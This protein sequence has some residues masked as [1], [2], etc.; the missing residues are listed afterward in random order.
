MTKILKG[1]DLRDKPGVSEPVPRRHVGIIQEEGGVLDHRVLS[2]S[3]KAEI[4][5][6]EAE[7]EAQKIRSEAEAVKNQIE[8]EREDARNEGFS[9]GKM[10]GLA[11]VT[12]KLMTLEKKKEEFFASAEPEIIKLVMA[13]A[14]K[15]IGQIAS[16][17][18]EVVKDVVKQALERSLG[19]RIVVKLNPE[20]YRKITDEHY[21]FRDVLD[22][23]KRIHLKE[24]ETIMKGGCVVETEVG[25][26]DAQIDTQ[27]EAIRKALEI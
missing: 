8:K 24:D 15:V 13:V 2:A 1:R 4:I 7:A 5:I 17:R 11:T 27:L 6:E 23:T 25:T 26:I 18:P 14:E 20:D 10:E 21:E 3:Q 16:E 22:R 19:D 12:E 9:K